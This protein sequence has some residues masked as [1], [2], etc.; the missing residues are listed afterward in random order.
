MVK[1]VTGVRPG[2]ERGKTL[3][4]SVARKG[5]REDE[6]E[7][8]ER[9]EAGREVWAAAKVEC[10]DR[11][12]GFFKQEHMKST[13]AKAHA[14][15]PQTHSCTPSNAVENKT[16]LSSSL[17]SRSVACVPFQIPSR[18]VWGVS[19]EPFGH[20][21]EHWGGWRGHKC[22]DTNRDGRSDNTGPVSLCRL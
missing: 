14:Q 16:F 5:R 18:H 17:F 15:H 12:Q 6:K 11:L 22:L 7:G 21:R 19:R 8:E 13:R 10:R 2:S 3:W 20:R 1:C 4:S 9:R